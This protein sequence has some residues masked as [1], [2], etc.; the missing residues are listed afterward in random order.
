MIIHKIFKFPYL[1]IYPTAHIFNLCMWIYAYGHM[2]VPKDC[3]SHLISPVIKMLRYHLENLV[4]SSH[5]QCP[6]CHLIPEQN[7]GFSWVFAFF[8]SAALELV[9]MAKWYKSAALQKL[10]T[11]DHG[12]LILLS[13]EQTTMCF[14]LQLQ[15]QL[16][17]YF[18]EGGHLS[19]SV[20]VLQ[21]SAHRHWLLK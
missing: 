17:F 3:F 13:C 8:K 6:S 16:C 15:N 19:L 21:W 2:L 9:R 20:S 7:R 18:Q 1:V 5:L 11:Y 12:F 10:E 14:V 4:Q